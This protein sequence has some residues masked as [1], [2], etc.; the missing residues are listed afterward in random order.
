M[1]IE[2]PPAKNP[3][4][5][6]GHSANGEF[7]RNGVNGNG[8]RQNNFETEA[9]RVF[10]FSAKSERSLVTYLSSFEEYLSRAP[11]TDDFMMNLSY[12]LG[13]RRT[14]FL[15]RVSFVADSIPF[16]LEKLSAAKPTRAKE[17]V[18]A[19]AFTGQGAQ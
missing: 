19:F 10:A 16:L 9:K 6:N 3:I 17:R 11:R 2:G 14:H 1:I 8:L 7:H 12:T 15:H 4:E 5:T 13:E 18:V